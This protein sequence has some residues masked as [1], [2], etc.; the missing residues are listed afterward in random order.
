MGWAIS[1]SSSCGQGSCSGTERGY[2]ACTQGNRIAQNHTKCCNQCCG[3]SAELERVPV[4]ACSVHDRGRLTPPTF[5]RTD[6]MSKVPPGMVRCWCWAFGTEIPIALPERTPHRRHGVPPL[7]RQ[8][9]I[10]ERSL[11]K[12]TSLQKTKEPYSS[13]ISRRW[14]VKHTINRRRPFRLLHAH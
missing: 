12:G 10:S 14:K 11:Y 1:R 9:R 6:F 3:Q 4:E 8:G 13:V 5:R 2:L 7:S